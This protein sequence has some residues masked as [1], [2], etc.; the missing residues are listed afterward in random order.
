MSKAYRGYLI[1]HNAMCG[2]WWIEKDG[3][4]IGGAKDEADAR[5]TIDMLVS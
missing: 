1:R 5:A 4:R 3:F 2:E